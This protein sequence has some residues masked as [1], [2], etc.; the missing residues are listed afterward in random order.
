MTTEL[1][2]LLSLHEGLDIGEKKIISF[3]TKFAFHTCQKLTHR[4]SSFMLTYL[5]KLHDFPGHL[6]LIF[7]DSVILTFPM[8]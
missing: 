2:G 3:Y 5:L 6:W 7:G 1:P 4:K 8:R